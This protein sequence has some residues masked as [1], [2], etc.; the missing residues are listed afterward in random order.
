MKPVQ[1]PKGY[2]YM[3]LEDEE[4]AQIAMSMTGVTFMGRKVKV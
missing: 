2:A 1:M 4:T 3:E